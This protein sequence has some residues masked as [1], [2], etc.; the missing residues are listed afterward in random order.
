VIFGFLGFQFLP[1]LPALAA[2]I[3]SGFLGTLAGRHILHR[4]PEKLFTQLF[5]AVLTVLGLRLLLLAFT[6]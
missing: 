3:L 5:R 4:L 6:G 1:W 2:M